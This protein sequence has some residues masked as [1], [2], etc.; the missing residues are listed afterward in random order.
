MLSKAGF[1]TDSNNF[2]QLKRLFKC[3]DNRC[4]ICLLYVIE[5]NRFVM[6]NNMRWELRSHVTCRVINVIYYLKCNVC[7]HKEPY[8]GKMTGNNVAGFKS[9]INQHIRDCR[10]GTSNCNFVIHVYHCAM[11]NRV[12]NR[13]WQ[14]KFYENHYHKK[15]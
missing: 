2:I 9:R 14:L 5:G 13:V 7:D 15:D 4:K 1:N 3:T 12:L 11:K 6:T 10:P 8:I